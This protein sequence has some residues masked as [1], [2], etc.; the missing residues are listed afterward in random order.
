MHIATISNRQ[1]HTITVTEWVGLELGTRH[2]RMPKKFIPSSEFSRMVK[3]LPPGCT[4]Y[5]Y[6]ELKFVH[7]V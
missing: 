3:Y 5:Y 6:I 2:V 4:Y 1:S 7:F